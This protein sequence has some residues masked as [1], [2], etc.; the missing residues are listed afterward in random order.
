MQTVSHFVVGGGAYAVAV[1]GL[2]DLRLTAARLP[3]HLA[4]L[5]TEAWRVQAPKYLRR[6]FDEADLPPGA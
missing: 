6:E 4:E 1:A 2:D 5:V 3:D